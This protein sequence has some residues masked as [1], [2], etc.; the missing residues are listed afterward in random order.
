MAE[1]E[2]WYEG[3]LSTR[4]VLKDNGAV[5]STDAPKEI[6]GLGRAFS[7]TD[8]LAA[9]VG[10]CILT[11]MGMVARRRQLDLKG[12]RLIITKEMQ[13]APAR[14][15][16]RIK[17]DLYCPQQF[18]PDVVDQL[19]KAAEACPVKQSLHPDIQQEITFH[20]GEA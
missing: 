13:A 9:S 8:L 15:V 10:S 11:M 16:G 4:C 19:T 14:R 17:V 18:S 5:I 7:P 6:Q 3:D 20:W 12:T 2:I 1:V